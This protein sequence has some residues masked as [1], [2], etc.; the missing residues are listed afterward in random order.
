M[1]AAG[2]GVL[3][4]GGEETVNKRPKNNRRSAK[5][6]FEKFWYFWEH[7]DITR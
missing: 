1:S 2:F 5:F 3:W 7:T 6:I 4:E